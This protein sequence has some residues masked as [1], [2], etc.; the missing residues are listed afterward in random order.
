MVFWIS[1]KRR[2]NLNGVYDVEIDIPDHIKAFIDEVVDSFVMWDLLIFASQRANE[3]D[4]PG[5][6]AQLL[7]R[8]EA[9][10]DKP[11]LKLVK[12]GVFMVER[13]ADGTSVC[14]MNQQSKLFPEIQQFL[15]FNEVQENRLRI[16]SYLLQ[17]KVS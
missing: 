9:E 3:I 16:L 14:K 11:F 17:K 2:L 15:A 5:R 13:Q 10:V 12:L 4:T 6:T 7:G 8:T 1:W